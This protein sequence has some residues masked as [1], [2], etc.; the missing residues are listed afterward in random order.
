M[1]FGRLI[2]WPRIQL[3]LKG[4][5][6]HVELPIHDIGV[7]IVGQEVAGQTVGVIKPDLP[8]ERSLS[9][10]TDLEEEESHGEGQEDGEQSPEVAH[11]IGYTKSLDPIRH[12]FPDRGLVWLRRTGLEISQI[13]LPN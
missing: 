3:I 2:Q 10:R 1:R 8:L 13:G 5:I 12:A 6:D 11:G 9:L 4:L 7:L